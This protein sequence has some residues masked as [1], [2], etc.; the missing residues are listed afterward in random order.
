[1]NDDDDGDGVV[2]TICGDDEG[3]DYARAVVGGVDE[4]GE[5]LELAV[6]A[7]RA[8]APRLLAVVLEKV[9][10]GASMVVVKD[11]GKLRLSWEQSLLSTVG[12][13]VTGA[14]ARARR[15]VADVVRRVRRAP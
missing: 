11:G 1:M 13:H 2:C 10:D 6:G 9:P 12:A 8:C 5:P 14:R 4:H 7:C 3:G 15:V